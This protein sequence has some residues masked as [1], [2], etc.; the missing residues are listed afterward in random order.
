MEDGKQKPF[1]QLVVIGSSAGGIEALSTLV[2]TLHQKFPAPVVIAQHLDP[3]RTSHLRQILSQRSTLPVR[4]LQDRER[5]E[6]GVVFVV[7]A[8]RHVEIT[9][10][11]IA[12]REEGHGRSKPSIDFLLTSAARLFG[13]ELV[14]VILT[15]TGSDGAAGAYEVK[16]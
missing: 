4:T 2:S 3:H 5:L 14:A 7:P 6:P 1:S 15:G 12:L 11:D 13:E 9:D 8:Y 10:H 16:N